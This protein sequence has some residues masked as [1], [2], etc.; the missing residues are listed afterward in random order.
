MFVKRTRHSS[1]QSSS[2]QALC[3][4]TPP[5]SSLSCSRM[6]M[7]CM[8][9]E[10]LPYIGKNAQ[11]QASSA[12]QSRLPAESKFIQGSH[13]GSVFFWVEAPEALLQL[14]K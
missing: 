2:S 12:D 11:V 8:S 10:R 1:P 9:N 4:L 6:Q 5:V 13:A 3:A 7:I 14:S